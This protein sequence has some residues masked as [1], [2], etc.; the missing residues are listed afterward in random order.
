MNYIEEY[1]VR[2]VDSAMK[3][4]AE[5]QVV[6]DQQQCRL[7]RRMTAASRSLQPTPEEGWRASKRSCKHANG[8][9]DRPD[10]IAAVAFP[11]SAKPASSAAAA[12]RP[13]SGATPVPIW[14]AALMATRCQAETSGEHHAVG[15]NCASGR[16]LYTNRGAG[17]ERIEPLGVSLQ[18]G[19]TLEV[20][21]RP[22][23][24]AYTMEVSGWPN[25][26]C[27]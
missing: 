11:G 27:A 6:T 8:G 20:Y 10:A 4:N 3:Q 24:T 14:L 23:E 13:L 12:C 1:E 22:G 21:W 15:W 17:T 25:R 16:A 9:P 5:E 7:S 19:Q 2:S 18:G 26:N